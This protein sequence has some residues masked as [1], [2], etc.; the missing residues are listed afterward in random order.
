MQPFTFH[1]RS[2]RL[3]EGLNNLSCAFQRGTS[4][5][6]L[7]MRLLH[8]YITTVTSTVGIPPCAFLFYKVRSTTPWNFGKLLRAPRLHTLCY[9]GSSG[10]LLHVICIVSFKS[11][12]VFRI[13]TP[14][15]SSVVASRKL[16][17]FWT[18]VQPALIEGL[19]SYHIGYQTYNW[20]DWSYCVIQL[21]FLH[22][23]P[24][25]RV[26]KCFG[27]NYLWWRAM[28]WE[29]LYLPSGLFVPQQKSSRY[30]ILTSL[31]RALIFVAVFT[32]I[33]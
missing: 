1:N 7:A 24:S 16:S 17:C 28:F 27:G 32:I 8:P 3:L 6:W 9:W 10:T 29:V 31:L 2:T 14:S 18:W 25:E 13:P 33:M 22:W 12:H 30:Y 23:L 11:V 20:P 15:N 21:N 5:G 4:H 19:W 26:S